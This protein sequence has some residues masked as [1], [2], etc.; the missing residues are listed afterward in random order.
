MDNMH[1]NGQGLSI[2]LFSWHTHKVLY[3]PPRE[4]SACTW[5]FSRCGGYTVGLMNIAS[6]TP[7]PVV[8]ISMELLFPPLWFPLEYFSTSD[9]GS[10]KIR[11]VENNS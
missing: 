5:K 3:P 7:A 10:G 1:G 11:E 9:L 4:Q 2:T 6:K 8:K